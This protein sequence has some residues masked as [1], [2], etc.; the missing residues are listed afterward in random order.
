MPLWYNGLHMVKDRVVSWVRRFTDMPVAGIDISDRSVKY[1]KFGRVGNV[2]LEA[3]GEVGMPEGAI[4]GGEIRRE[5]DVARIFSDLARR[6]K[7]LRGSAVVASLPEEKSFL[8]P[9][10]LKNVKPEDMEG[11]I[12][13]E[14]EKQIPLSADDVA[15]GYE[16]MPGYGAEDGHIDAVLIA[17][18]KALVESYVRVLTGA[19]L[20]LAAL[21]LESQAIVRATVPAGAGDGAR[22]IVD[23]G[24]N[25]T[26]FAIVD[27]GGIVF[28][29]TVAVGGQLLEERIVQALGVDGNEAMRIKN[30]IGL[31]KSFSEG[32]IFSALIPAVGAFADELQR[33]IQSYQSHLAHEQGVGGGITEI[34]LSGGDAN[35]F[36]LDTYLAAATRIPCRRAD[37]FAAVRPRMALGVPPIPYHE[38][39]AYAAAIGLALRPMHEEP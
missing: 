10:R 35:L 18:P 1:V 19:G 15:Y 4:V 20:R 12:R 39:L 36:G 22:V 9:V 38:S 31:A 26:S 2:F 5:E 37:S 6:E 33:A 28:T 11:A 7:C 34:L 23:M 21:E 14:I 27:G 30:E 13:W 16:A 8:R 25:R 29:T 32:K 3:F 17:F 24:R